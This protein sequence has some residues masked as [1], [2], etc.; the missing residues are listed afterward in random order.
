MSL[1]A[2]YIDIA[3]FTVAGDLTSSF[4]EGRRVKANC[5]VDG[6]KYRTVESSS[7]DGTADTTVNLYADS[8]ALTS[9]LTEVWYGI[10]GVGAD[11]SLPDHLHN[12]VEGSGGEIITLL[13][14][15]YFNNDSTSPRVI[16]LI[17]GINITDGV[18]SGATVTFASD[19]LYISNNDADGL[20]YITG[21]K[22]AGGQ[23]TMA[24]FD[25][26]GAAELYYDGVKTLET[27][28]GEVW[29]YDPTATEFLQLKHTGTLAE[30]RNTANGGSVQLS[31]DDAG[32]D[33]QRILLGTATSWTLYNTGVKQLEGGV[34]EV[35]LYSSGEVL[36]G[37]FKHDG[38][39]LLL[40]NAVDSGH[41]YLQADNVSSALTSLFK[42]DPDGAAELYHAGTKVFE[43][44]AA[45][46]SIGDGV[47][48]AATIG[49]TTDDL[50]ISNND[51]DGFIYIKG[52][53]AASASVEFIRLNPGG[54]ARLFDTGVQRFETTTS[55]VR[56]WG[57]G[58]LATQYADHSCSGTYSLD[59]NGVGGAYMR[60]RLPDNTGP[61]GV[62]TT[63][64]TASYLTGFNLYFQG[65]WVMS[66]TAGG[67]TT[68]N[69]SAEY[70]TWYTAAGGTA[71][72][73]PATDG[74][75][76]TVNT[77]VS[78]GTRTGLKVIAAGAVELYYNNIKTFETGSGQV[79]IYN[80]D[81]SENVLFYNETVVDGIFEIR[82]RQHGGKIKL[83]GESLA[84]GA[85]KDMLLAD[86]DGA[87]DLYHDG[88]KTVST[89][90]NGI[91]VM[92]GDDSTSG[93]AFYSN[94]GTTFGLYGFEHGT[95]IRL[96]AENNAGDG[97]TMFQGDPDGA[98][99]LYYAGTKVFETDSTGVIV[100][101][102][103][104][105][106]DLY[107]TGDTIHVGTGEIKSTAGNIELYYAGIKT[108][109][110][111]L[112][113]ADITGVLVSDG[114]DIADYHH[115]RIGSSQTLDIF[116]DG[117]NSNFNLQSGQI[118][119]SLLGSNT[120]AKFIST[121]AVELYYDGVKTVSTYFEE[122]EA[123]DRHGI[124]IFSGDNSTHISVSDVVGANFR[125]TNQIDSGSVALQGHNDS[126]IAVNMLLARP[127]EYV[128]LFYDGTGVFETTSDGIKLNLGAATINEFSTDATLVGNSD[129]AVPTEKA[130]KT[131]VDNRTGGTNFIINGSMNI[132]Q[133]GTS[134]VSALSPAYFADR[135]RI[136]FLGAG[137]E[138]TVTRSTEVPSE[139]QVGAV[140]H[141]SLKIDVTGTYD[142][143]A[144][145]DFAVIEHGIEGYD[146]QKLKGNTITIS[147]WVRSHKTGTY[148]VT[149]RNGGIDRSYASIYTIDVADT[150]EKKSSTL[151]L[152][153][154]DS[155]EIY[156]SAKGLSVMWALIPTVNYGGTPDTWLEGNYVAA[157][158]QVNLFDSTAN[159]FYI[160]AIQLELGSEATA[161]KFRPIGEELALCQRYYAQSVSG[162]LDYL[163]W[164][165]RCYSG[166]DYSQ[167]H[168]FP[169]EMRAIPTLVLTDAGALGFAS[170]S[171]TGTPGKKGFFETRTCNSTLNVGY[172]KSYWTASSDI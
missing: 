90:S 106:D 122:I 75:G 125:I 152:D 100:T 130:V 148:S 132:W 36:G 140:V 21:E 44:T 154:T 85:I 41:V 67:F 167:T 78:G 142:T 119:F 121:G 113:G 172:F 169:V 73:A 34:A 156:T 164:S 138:R 157:I 42:G 11:Q 10:V 29:I 149:V 53:N 46:I 136:P 103:I 104:H 92:L 79:V 69:T 15:I 37:V 124:T 153:Q 24:L 94:T 83:S 17:D 33:T 147:F 31:V 50:Y 160:T 4:H 76:L 105:C 150:W 1:G 48:T 146:Y 89:I 16:A 116:F 62:Q 127:D 99:E 165:G 84:A 155:S 58:N 72:I 77:R 3:S 110:T 134:F 117:A 7:F 96:M 9:N 133:R 166:S 88:V 56:I 118:V 18:G 22:A 12:G 97:K 49:F 23:A 13:D 25:P 123:N 139:S 115:L 43:T 108:F 114:L 170:E 120:L 20:V 131:Y 163:F 87:V 95:P 51:P 2:T 57:I 59:F 60:M 109:E 30:I 39:D 64:M 6:F 168:Q 32:G 162:D 55:G 52:V 98:T 102:D 151:T 8:D 5:G 61:P 19:D 158:G 101:G 112:T 141:Y 91:G 137:I 54:Y 81:A 111:T 28:S 171:G 93:A 40:R 35:Y 80:F 129:T 143:P 68:R 38:T 66:T 159:D 144:D 45:G 14:R 65:S 135:F 47:A 161:F 107:T 74:A 71:T 70:A 27:Y 128:R 126:S 63:I 26:D 82:N 145:N 86:P